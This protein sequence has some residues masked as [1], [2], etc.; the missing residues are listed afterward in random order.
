MNE[1]EKQI[2]YTIISHYIETGESV[3]S[4]TIE[5]KYDIGVSSATIRNAMADLED[6]GLISKTHTSSGRIPTYDGYKLY[7]DN[8]LNE[9]D[10]EYTHNIDVN[11][12]A[13]LKNEQVS[14]IIENVTQMLSKL[15][16]NA[17]IALEPSNE[18]HSLKKVELVYV[19]NKR[20][21]IVAV[22]DMNIVKTANLNLYNYIDETVLKK[23]SEYIN[24]LI[25]EQKGKYTINS[26]KTFFEKVG[27]LDKGLSQES[28]T[29]LH[30][31]NETSLLINSE[32]VFKTIKILD[33]KNILKN[34]LKDI[35]ENKKYKPY[36]INILFGNELEYD[37]LKNYIFIF[38]VY[39]YANERG[40]ISLIGPC[41]MNYK[42][43][44]N[45][46]NYIN[47]ILKQA[48]NKT[49]SLKL[50]K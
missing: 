27:S 4:R 14:L 23:V 40:V 39:E 21:F 34:I 10:F 24:L 29:K 28:D 32:D 42:K 17:A 1:R 41:R 8:L 46:I 48:L 49:V 12:Y 13:Q 38:S 19:N 18:N 37:E 43:N 44:I 20:A 7:V 25:A 50:I 3:G 36:E 45:L 16:S 31:S 35:V 26:L 15:S 22:T 47:E 33:D 9:N 30:M 2:L 11:S 5:K 6:M